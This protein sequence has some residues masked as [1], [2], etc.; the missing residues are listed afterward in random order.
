MAKK[1]LVEAK[2]TLDTKDYEKNLNNVSKKTEQEMNKI[3]NTS[4]KMATNINN[5]NKKISLSN[6]NLARNYGTLRTSSSADMDK[7]RQ[8]TRTLRTNAE[9]TNRNIQTS[10]NNLA[11]SYGTLRASTA[12]DMAKIRQNFSNTSASVQASNRQMTSSAVTMA[13]N[14]ANVQAQLNAD[15]QRWANLAQRV[16]V[17]YSNMSSGVA[18]SASA[19]TS[20]M[21]GIGRLASNISST[22]SNM[23]SRISGAVSGMT[24]GVSSAFSSIGS[25]ISSAH[26]TVSGAVSG[27]ASSFTSF[28]T[29]SGRVTQALEKIQNKA[30]DVGNALTNMGSKLTKTVTL[31]LTGLGTVAMKSAVDFDYSMSKVNTLIGLTGKEFEDFEAKLQKTSKGMSTDLNEFA[32]ATYQAISAGVDY[33]EAIDF[34]GEAVKLAKGGFMDTATAVSSLT[35]IMNTYGEKAG[36]LTEIQDKLV[37]VQNYGVTTVGELSVGLADV[38][39]TASSLNMEFNEMLGVFTHVTKKGNTASKTATML[40]AMLS[41]LGKAGTKA[42]D[43]LKK[44]TGKSFQQLMKDGKGL[45]EVLVILQESAKKSGLSLGDMFGSVEASSIA[46]TI[47]GDLEGFKDAIDKVGNSAGLAGASYEEMA[48]TMK[49]KI[50]SAFIEMQSS[51]VDIGQKM[52]PLLDKVLD[53]FKELPRLLNGIDFEAVFT[54][55]I[56]AVGDILKLITDLMKKFQGLD[57]DT[58]ELIAKGTIAMGFLGPILSFIGLLALG[59]SS[60]VGVI[61]GVVKFFTTGF[62]ATIVGAIKSVVGWIATLCG[63]ANWV[64]WVV[65]AIVAA[66]VLMVKNWDKVKEAGGKACEWIGEKMSALADWVGNAMDNIANWVGNAMNKAVEW[67]QKAWDGFKEFFSGIWDSCVEKV[68]GFFDSVG[69][70]FDNI[71]NAVGNGMDY[72]GQLIEVGIDFILNI[73]DIGVQLLLLPWIFVW[74]NF[75]DIIVEAFERMCM[76]VE[77][78]LNKIVEFF[79]PIGETIAETWNSIWEGL[80]N[81]ITT[82]IETSQEVWNILVEVIGIV[83]DT[84]RETALEKWNEFVSTLTEAWTFLS[85]IASGVF[86][87]L[88]EVIGGALDGAYAWLSEQWSATSAWLSEQWN[89]FMGIASSIFGII[90]S[91]ISGVWTTMCSIVQGAWSAF[92]SWWSSVTSTASSIVQG[93]ISGVCGFIQTAFQGAVTVAKGIWDGLF[94]KVQE[95]VNKVRGGIEGLV[96]F[97]KGAFKF[98]WKLPDL[99]LPKISIT[100]K[101]SLDPPSTP[102]FTLSWHHDGAIFTNPTVMGAHGVG[103]GFKGLGAKRE[104]VMPIEKLPDLLGLNEKSNGDFTLNIENFENNR[105]MDIEQLVKEIGYFARKRGLEFGL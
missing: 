34:V 78:G 14:M 40:K 58:Q 32:E 62:G 15:S 93:L 9:T 41:E 22:F 50:K 37:S 4:D 55:F 31:P 28:I 95:I 101:F 24:S 83:F 67:A 2:I 5:A 99:K 60:L 69:K 65:L 46:N 29:D 73:I 70:V 1:N 79:A 63:V 51:M 59:F 97:L 49:D 82:F 84:I 6:N 12:S 64:V 85:E 23:G 90:S 96:T 26:S 45:D 57:K 39:P 102:K 18:S 3:K 30:K 10:N 104:A 103:D 94:T 74:Q 80:T 56:D 68:S 52:E 21:S 61:G 75:G 16:N 98:S 35:T 27:M 17:A 88:S 92:T 42:S 33:G 86:S 100:G 71:S 7:I 76:W 91:V 36:N 13:N 89:A 53:A 105:E 44:K 25:A 48:S 72:I 19:T 20:S 43:I 47:V 11:R 77:E 8:S 87:Y 81:A 38:I 66:I 54:P